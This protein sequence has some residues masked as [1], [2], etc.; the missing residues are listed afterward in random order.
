MEQTRQGVRR[1]V[2]LLVI[3]GDRGGEILR[4]RL[5]GLFQSLAEG[6]TVFGRGL[7]RFANDRMDQVFQVVEVLEAG[8]AIGFESLGRGS[9]AFPLDR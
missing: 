2:A 7:V 3:L 8:A 5:F 6:L 4:D 9:L 1:K